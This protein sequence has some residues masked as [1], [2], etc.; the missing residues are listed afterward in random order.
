MQAKDAIGQAQE[1]ATDVYKQAKDTIAGKASSLK[2]PHKFAMLQ[3][4]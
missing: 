4:A 1:K 3:A 2:S